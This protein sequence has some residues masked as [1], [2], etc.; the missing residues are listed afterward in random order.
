MSSTEPPEANRPDASEPIPEQAAAERPTIEQPTTELTPNANPTG[1]TSRAG[2][3]VGFGPAGAGPVAPSTRRRWPWVVG[4]VAVV[5]VALLVGAAVTLGALHHM[6]GH[7][8][9]A[10]GWPGLAGPARWPGEGHGWQFGGWDGAPR[11]GRWGGA[12]GGVAGS[13]MLLG[14]VASV[15]G[16]NLV[17]T[18]DGGAQPVT[19]AT[20]DLTRVGGAQVRALSDLKTGDRVAV[21]VA[22]DH[23]AYGV[24]VVPAI[25]WGTVTAL[26]GTSATITEPDG[27]TQAV[28]TSALP[29]Q[30][31]VGDLVAVRGTV[32]GSTI[33]AQDLR[34]LPKTG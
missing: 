34:E 33:K 15:N 12:Q 19:V 31:R 6:R 21:R 9:F 28:D 13:S 3:P 24:L 7:E 5:L 23:S 32:T 17:V 22:P 20:T 11:G 4:G 18:P 25:T 27:L 10:A 14:S 30:P 16:A 29:T 1:P 8:R 26:T 2:D